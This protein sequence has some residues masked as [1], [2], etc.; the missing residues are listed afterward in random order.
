MYS[1]AMLFILFLCI[2]IT[3][4]IFVCLR[5]Q[6]ADDK[7]DKIRELP[8]LDDPIAILSRNRNEQT[9]SGDQRH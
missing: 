8:N 3:I 9:E 6:A 5:E 1:T 7:I 4:T 2:I